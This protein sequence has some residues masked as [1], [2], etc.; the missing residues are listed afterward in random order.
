MMI[1]ITILF[2]QE[3]PDCPFA[4]DIHLSI[5]WSALLFYLHQLLSSILKFTGLQINI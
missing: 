1:Y 3:V 5:N 4:N 2:T